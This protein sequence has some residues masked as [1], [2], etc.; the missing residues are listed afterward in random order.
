MSMYL[1]YCSRFVTGFSFERVPLRLFVVN[2]LRKTN[3]L[4]KAL[5]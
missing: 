3:K 5:R 4:K 2:A 1:K